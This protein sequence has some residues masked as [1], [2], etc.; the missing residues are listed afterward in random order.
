MASG[1]LALGLG[2]GL[3]LGVMGSGHKGPGKPNHQ[4][5]GKGVFWDVSI[6]Q[7]RVLGKL[8]TLDPI[9]TSMVGGGPTRDTMTVI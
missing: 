7:G 6:E 9:Q 8:W 2:L 1:R 5:V 4:V 3:V